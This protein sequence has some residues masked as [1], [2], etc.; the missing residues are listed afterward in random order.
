MFDT[1][2]ERYAT[3]FFG[4]TAVEE[5]LATALASPIVNNKFAVDEKL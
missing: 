3:L 5:G 1:S 2:L 4:R